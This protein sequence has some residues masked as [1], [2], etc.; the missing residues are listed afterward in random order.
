VVT[1]LDRDDAATGSPGSASLESWGQNLITV[2][3]GRKVVRTQYVGF[4]DGD[5]V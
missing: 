2:F 3:W 5:V 4:W 1:W